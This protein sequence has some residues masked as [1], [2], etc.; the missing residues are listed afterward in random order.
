MPQGYPSSIP[1]VLTATSADLAVVRLHGHS[2]RWESKNIEE[3]FDYCYSQEELTAWADRIRALAR[4]ATVTQVLFN[5]TYRG[6][7]QVNAQQ[8]TALLARAD[9][10]G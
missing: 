7:G 5:N 8:L 6:H 3:R 2:D 4:A 1:P 10:T 9:M